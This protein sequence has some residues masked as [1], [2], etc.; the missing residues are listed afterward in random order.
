MLLLLRMYASLSILCHAMGDIAMGVRHR[1]ML[2]SQADATH[3]VSL[4][5]AHLGAQQVLEIP[6]G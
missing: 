5:V 6:S 3:N 4:F 1:A 2:C